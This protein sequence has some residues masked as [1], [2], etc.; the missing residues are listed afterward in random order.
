VQL[1]YKVLNDIEN[2]NGCTPTKVGESAEWICNINSAENR[3]NFCKLLGRKP[4]FSVLY[5]I[6][7]VTL[8]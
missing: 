6:N 2:L 8:N 3:A 5:G 4:I 1:V 7:G